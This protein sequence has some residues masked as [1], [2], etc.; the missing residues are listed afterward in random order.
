MLCCR[1][2]QHPSPDTD[3]TTTWLMCNYSCCPCRGVS[4][5]R[6]QGRG[7]HFSEPSFDPVPW[8]ESLAAR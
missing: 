2:L 4:G 1:P 3:P 6:A 7:V 8:L 5:E